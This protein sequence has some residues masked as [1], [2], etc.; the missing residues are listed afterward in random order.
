LS[1]P[2][3]AGKITTGESPVIS[4]QSPARGQYTRREKITW[5]HVGPLRPA[6]WPTSLRR[7]KKRTEQSATQPEKHKPIRPLRG[8]TATYP[9]SK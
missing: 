8:K 5:A 1:Y 7:Q 9:L 2:G 6:L 3:K 4:L